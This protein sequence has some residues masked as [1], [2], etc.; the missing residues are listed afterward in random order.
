MARETELGSPADWAVKGEGNAN[1][2]LEYRGALPHLAGWVLRVRKARPPPQERDEALEREVGAHVSPAF[3]DQLCAVS[4]RPRGML[5]P[6]AAAL[7]PD[8]SLLPAPGSGEHA[9]GSSSSS[10]RGAPIS[11][12]ALELS[13]ATSTSGGASASTGTGDGDPAPAVLCVELKPKCGFVG[14]ACPTVHPRNRRVKRSASRYQLHQTLKVAQGKV[15]RRSGYDPADLF[16]D[17]QPERTASAL[18][19]LLRHPQNNLALFADGRRVEPPVAAHTVCE[20][21]RGTTSMAAATAQE[22]PANSSEGG[23]G[24]VAAATQRLFMP[25]P[26]QERPATLARVLQA[27]LEQEGVLP[28]LLAAQQLCK[29]DVEGVYALYCLLAGDAPAAAPEAAAAAA[30]V[31][32]SEEAAGTEAAAAA[33]TGAA[34]ATAEEADE[35]RQQAEAVRQLLALPRQQ[36]LGVL[37]DYS[38][39]ATAKD[40]ALMIALQRLPAA[41]ALRAQAA[42]ASACEQRGSGGFGAWTWT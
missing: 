42:P 4:G 18:A 27:V 40:C 29:Y 13:A 6:A 19:Q 34:A 15:G 2:V 31:Q 41:A 32:Q 16:A 14:G 22:D 20:L 5:H 1:V 39:S 10:S 37:R 35:E 9:S 7:M 21:G 17:D 12:V 3:C 25:L 38:V 24:W 8:V 28:R 11:M 23:L 26:A 33:A 30:A 36:A